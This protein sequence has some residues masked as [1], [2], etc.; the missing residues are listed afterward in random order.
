MRGV[1]GAQLTRLHN[2]SAQT[3][4]HTQQNQWI[5]QPSAKGGHHRNLSAKEERSRW[6]GERSPCK[7]V[8]S[9]VYQFHNGAI[10]IQGI[11]RT[12]LG[13]G[14]KNILEPAALG[15]KFQAR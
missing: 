9:R 15:S 11:A 7:R 13:N 8:L 10:V 5:M 4:H 1:A 2:E 3:R 12:K 6:S 14:R